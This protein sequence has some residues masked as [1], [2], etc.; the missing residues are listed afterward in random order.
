M[1]DISSTYNY[2]HHFETN[3]KPHFE[4]NSSP[5]VRFSEQEEFNLGM[6]TKRLF[7]KAVHRH[8]VTNHQFQ[9]DFVFSSLDWYLKIFFFFFLFLLLCLFFLI[10]RHEKGL[11][12][13][14]D[15]NLRINV[16]YGVPSTAS[17]LAFDPIQR[18]LA[19]GTL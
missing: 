4:I 5:N 17:I 10:Q 7:Q 2:T 18:L 13:S 1:F 8:Q 6:F 15:V 16:H 3:R 14:D 11:L 19:I 12:T 9:V